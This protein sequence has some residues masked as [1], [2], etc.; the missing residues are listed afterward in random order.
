MRDPSA[1]LWKATDIRPS[2]GEHSRL[3][4]HVAGL[5]GVLPQEALRV[6]NLWLIPGE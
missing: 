4:A 3:L 6:H 2:D 5:S 1:D